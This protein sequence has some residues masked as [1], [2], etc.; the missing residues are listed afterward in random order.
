VQPVPGQIDMTMAQNGTLQPP[1]GAVAA[2][3][4]WGFA[5]QCREIAFTVGNRVATLT[6]LNGS[7]SPYDLG[8]APMVVVG[9]GGDN[10][11]WLVKNFPNIYKP[12]TIKFD[13]NGPVAALYAPFIPIAEACGVPAANIEWDGTHL[14]V[15]GYYGHADNY[16]VLTVGSRDVVAKTDG[17]NPEVAI[18][19]N[20]LYYPL[21]VLNG[22]P[23][24]GITSVS[25]FNKMLFAAPGAPNLINTPPNGDS[26]RY[27][28]GTA[29]V[30][31]YVK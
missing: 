4:E 10:G 21:V 18:V 23:A 17:D 14:A 1:A 8:V 19:S 31:C 16:R 3:S 2:P 11:D 29:A 5:P 27:E 15:F 20:A 22:Q 6:A 26:W 13:A 24:L 12:G 7:T 28:T 25:D 30:G 9:P